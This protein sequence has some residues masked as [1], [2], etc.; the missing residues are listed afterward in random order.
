MGYLTIGI[1][2]KNLSVWIQSVSKANF[3][4]LEGA[5][6]RLKLAPPIGCVMFQTVSLVLY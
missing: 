1:L 6:Q 5:K 3:E 4:K 2:H